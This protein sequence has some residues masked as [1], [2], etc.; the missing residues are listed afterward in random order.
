MNFSGDIALAFD[1]DDTL[2]DERE[3]CRECIGH[4]ARVVGDM[5]G[6]DPGELAREMSQG[7]NPYDALRRHRPDVPLEINDFLDIYRSTVPASLPLRPDALRLLETL[8]A[9]RPDIPRY[10]ITDGRLHG[11]NAKIAALGLGRFFGPANIIVSD[12]IGSDKHT[13]TPF[14]TAMT[15]AGRRDGWCY[16]GDNPAKDF[17]WPRRLGWF[18]AMVADRGANIHPQPPLQ[19]IDEAFRPDIT[20]N[21]LDYITSRLCLQHS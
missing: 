2:Y 13:P 21:S 5:F 11:Q 17:H 19:Q 14:V 8:A 4:V 20:I 7:P 6:L 18:T 10:I 16:V 9:S 12:A 15:R 1:L 3:Y